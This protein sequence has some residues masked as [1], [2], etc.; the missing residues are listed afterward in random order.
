[1]KLVLQVAIV[2][3]LVGSALCGISQSTTHLIVFRALQGLGGGGLI[4]SSMAAVGDVVSPRERGL[5]QGYFGAMF[6]VSTVV[7]PIVG[8]YIVEDLSWRW[9][10]Y[11]NLPVG[12]ASFIVLSW[13][14]AAP[15]KREPRPIDWVG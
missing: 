10:F 4:V 6:G 9:I 1:R 13:A 14:F 8:G 11:V 15:P 7:G 5:Y 2:L 3:F 12:L